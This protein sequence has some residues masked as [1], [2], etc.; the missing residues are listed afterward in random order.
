MTGYGN[1]SINK[2][3]NRKKIIIAAAVIAAL[4]MAL[5][6]SIGLTVGGGAERAES[7]S[8]AVA[9]N[10][11]LK[12]QVS[13]LK[14]EIIRMQEEIDMLNA[15]LESRPAATEQYEQP[16]PSPAGEDGTVYSPR[17]GI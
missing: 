5:V 10:I 3:N 17:E 12:Q 11:G 13:E 16:V 7:I 9:E 4:L 2:R 15:E 14:A 8:A 6:Y 1:F